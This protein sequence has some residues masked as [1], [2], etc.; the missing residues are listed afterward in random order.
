MSLWKLSGPTLLLFPLPF[1]LAS[2]LSSLSHH[3]KHCEISLVLVAFLLMLVACKYTQKVP[4]PFSHTSHSQSLPLSFTKTV[5][6]MVCLRISPLLPVLSLFLYLRL[7]C[8][9][10]PLI[11][12]PEPVDSLS[13]RCL[14][15]DSRI[16]SSI[17][18]VQSTTCR[19]PPPLH[20]PPPLSFLFL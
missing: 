9:L 16:L 20:S 5:C 14:H 10:C 4:L 13:S 12:S 18:P 3:R 19:T 7:S 6:V 11:V 15:A 8:S 2:L 1:S 17:R